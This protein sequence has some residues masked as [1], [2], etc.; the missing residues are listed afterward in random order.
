MAAHAFIDRYAYVVDKY[1]CDWSDLEQLDMYMC[2][3]AGHSQW[4]LPV[5]EDLERWA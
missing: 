2:D 3:V 4:R 5:E 1:S